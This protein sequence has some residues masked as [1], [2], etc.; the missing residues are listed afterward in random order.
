MHEAIYSLLMMEKG[1]LAKS[2]N[3]DN[4]VDE[5]AGMNILQERKDEKVRVTSVMHSF[6]KSTHI[7]RGHKDG[8]VRMFSVIHSWTLTRNVMGEHT[9]GKMRMFSMINLSCDDNFFT[10]QS[11][12][13][14][15]FSCN[16]TT[17]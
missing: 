17:D 7:L 14:T 10:D 3:I 9:N 12:A 1:F 8:I 5:A 6:E 13:K 4:L 11:S 16:N 15:E 2:A